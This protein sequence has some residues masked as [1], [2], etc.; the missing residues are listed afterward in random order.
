MRYLFA[1]AA[2]AVAAPLAA[3][4]PWVPGSEI[5]GQSAQVTTAG[6][7]NTVYLDAGGHARIVTPGGQTVPASWTASG[8]RLC[9]LT[10]SATECW[11]Y[12]APFQAQ[13]LTALSSSCGGLSE[14]VMNGVN[15]MPAPPPPPVSEV[16]GE[17]G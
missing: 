14:W 16:L 15:A 10:G 5:V 12:E 3:Q 8:Q 2:F 4:S 17:R 11:P 1:I 7:T 6:V 13:K 9:L